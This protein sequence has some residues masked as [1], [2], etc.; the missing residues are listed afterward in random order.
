M[1]NKILTKYKTSK[2]ARTLTGNFISLS[3]LQFVGYIFPLITLPYLARVLGVEKFGVL[4]FASSIVAYFQAFVDYGF[5]YTAVREIA[6]QKKSIDVISKIFSIVMTTRAFLAGISL[7]LLFVLILI[8]PLFR[9]NKKILLLTFA[10][11]PAYLLFPVWLFQALE[12]MKYITILNVISKIL[13][14]VLVF[15]IIQKA[16]DF[17]WQPVLSAIGYLVAGIFSLLII[18]I[19]F[20]IRYILPQIPDIIAAIK[21]SW[22]MFVTIFVPNIY[23]NFS[24]ILLRTFGGET[25]TGI[26]N[27]GDKFVILANQMANVLSR[28][29]Y[30]FLARRLDKHDFYKKVSFVISIIMSLTLFLS[31]DLIIKIFYTDEFS[32]ASMVLRI[33]SL[34]IVPLFLMNTFGTNYL[35]LVNQE[36]KFK[37]IILLC[38]FIGF[39]FSWAAIYY[40]NYLGAAVLYL[41][42]RGLMGLLIWLAAIKHMNKSKEERAKVLYVKDF[43]EET[44]TSDANY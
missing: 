24:V 11:I 23:T 33:L 3:V 43:F 8:V 42:V 18:K 6:Q 38:S 32:N 16:E 17:Y 28:T 7:F 37:N 26:F 39:A 27:A 35:V 10:Y 25:S 5:N 30:P 4:A 22:N 13:F 15:I 31:A 20:K 1:I 41:M 29:F 12:S 19:K 40:F 36:R 44:G 14:T 2:D 21:E 34:T 9:E